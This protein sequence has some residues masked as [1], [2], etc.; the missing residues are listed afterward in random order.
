MLDPAA[1]GPGAGFAAAV[2]RLSA[3]AHATAPLDERSPVVVPGERGEREYRERLRLGIPISLEERAALAAALAE[4]GLAA[5][6]PDYPAGVPR[7]RAGLSAVRS[8]RLEEE[9][10]RELGGSLEVVGYERFVADPRPCDVLLN[11]CGEAVTPA[12]LDASRPSCVVGYGVG[13]N[14]ID[15]AAARERGMRVVNMPLANVPDVAAHALALIL[16]CSRRLVA[17]DREVRNGGFDWTRAGLPVRL[18]GRRLGLIAFGNIPRQLARLLAPHG[19]ELAAHDPHVDPGVMV[20]HGVRPVTELD[21]SLAGSQIV[22]LHA[23]ETPETR[24][25]LDRRRLALLPRGAIVVVTGRGSTYDAE[26]LA[27]ALADGEPRR[28]ASTSSPTSR[29]RPAIRC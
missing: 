18:A 25:L 22:S 13:T 11:A 21:E 17:A 24:N 14:W 1:F 29:R 23:P 26:A 4:L 8:L 15:L 6:L 7:R 28:P 20:Q 9:A 27:E 19:A 16:A 5:E 12:L 3:Q 2:E 10:C